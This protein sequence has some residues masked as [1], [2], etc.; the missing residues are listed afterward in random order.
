MTESS[1]RA[2]HGE[3]YEYGRCAFPLCGRRFRRLKGPGRP[4]RYCQDACRRRAQRVRSHRRT[5]QSPPAHTLREGVGAALRLQTLAEELAEAER[6]GSDLEE[7]AGLALALSAQAGC[8]LGAAVHDA[9]AKG[10]GWSDVARRTHVSEAA[11]RAM[12][13]PRNPPPPV[14]GH[15]HYDKSPTTDPAESETGPAPAADSRRL[16]AAVSCLLRTHGVTVQETAR[17]TDLSFAC[18][19]RLVTG[20]RVPDWPVLFTA[21]TAAGGRPEEFRILWEWARKVQ[22]LPRRSAAASLARFHNALR[23]LQWASGQ[24]AA[25]AVL[26]D[27]GVL[28]AVLD[29]EM[30]PDWAMTRQIVQELKGNPDQVKDLWEDVHRSF[31]ITSGFLSSQEVPDADDLT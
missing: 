2:G 18:I 31:L 8:Y 16:G 10:L 17:R 7:L 27:H 11:A 14:S 3:R 13:G 28:A 9:R 23:G 26:N 15:D 21:V 22:R 30:V 19:L 1:P 20:Q 24:A 25:G 29:G 5:E 6:R 12:W 4:R